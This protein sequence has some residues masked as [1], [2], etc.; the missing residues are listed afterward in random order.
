MVDVR[1]LLEYNEEVR[2]RYFVCLTG[3]SW[4]DFTEN[5]EASFNSMRNIFVHTL[6]ALDHWLDRL[7]NENLRSKKKYDEYKSFDDVK[8]YMKSVEKRTYNYLNSLTK[9]TLNKKYAMKDDE[10]KTHRFTAEDILI[11]MFEEEVHH[12]GEL[13]ALLL[14]I[15]VEPP[16]MGWKD[17]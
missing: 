13:I 5:R 15:G 8:T 16:S 12:R 1:Q 2:N 14:Q 7:K 10:G 6:G 17:L 11:H 9:S 3:L 4:K